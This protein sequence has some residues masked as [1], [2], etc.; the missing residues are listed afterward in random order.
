MKRRTL[1]ISLAALPLAA[2]ETLDPALIESVL[3][4]G[5]LTEGEAALGIREALDFGVGNALSGLGRTDG[6]FGNPDVRIPL[7]GVLRDVQSYLVPLGAGGLLS[8]LEEQ[9][10][11]GAEAAVPAAANIFLDAIRGLTIQDAIGIVQGPETA[12]TD[13]LRDRTTDGLTALF[14]PVMEDALANTGALRLVDEI[15]SQIGFGAAVGIDT[16]F[17]DDLVRHGV[18]FGLAGVFRFIAAEEAAIRRD[19]AERTTAIL[20]R[21][22][23]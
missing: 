15:E 20:R 13:Y 2:C 6:F 12:A 5:P 18:K 7:P 14:S 9:L 3:G 16:D 1:L 17:S 8:E 19:P 4:G 22:F 23:G 21:V 11:R 10:N